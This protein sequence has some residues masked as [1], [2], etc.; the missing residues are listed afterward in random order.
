MWGGGGGGGGGGGAVISGTQWTVS[1]TSRAVSMVMTSSRS[2]QPETE[3]DSKNFS[4][5][6]NHR[7]TKSHIHQIK[8]P[9]WLLREWQ[10]VTTK[11]SPWRLSV[12]LSVRLWPTTMQPRVSSLVRVQGEGH[13]ARSTYLPHRRLRQLS[14]QLDFR[15]RLR[16]R[17]PHVTV[18]CCVGGKCLPTMLALQQKKCQRM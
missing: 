17:P 16:M 6:E 4:S 1:V 14:P 12:R 3:E 7:I 5:P 18:V 10:N 15:D 11:K 13:C 9:L 8:W 2:W